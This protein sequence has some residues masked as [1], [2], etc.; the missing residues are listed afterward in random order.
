MA[1]AI[2]TSS[3]CPGSRRRSRGGGTRASRR[4]HVDGSARSH[5]GFNVEFAI[6][7]DIDNDGKAQEVVAQ[8]NGTPQ[9]W[10]EVEGR[11]LGPPRRQRSELRPRHRR[12]RRQRRRPHRHPDA[13]RLAR[14]AGGSAGGQLDLSRRLGGRQYAGDASPQPGAPPAAAPRARSRSS[15]SCTCSTSTATAG[16]TSSPAAGHDYG[17]FWFEQGENGQWTRRI[18]RQRLVAG[19]RLDARRPERRRP[20]G[21]R[22]R[23]ALHGPQRQRSR[24]TRAARRL[25]V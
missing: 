3:R 23:Q 7:A 12:R 1:T 22:H 25:L 20:A 10:Y 16:T 9:A 24:R 14:G 6:L 13:A 2:P 8:E 18:D 11:A 19:A 17:V 21:S 4:R 15:A 5:T